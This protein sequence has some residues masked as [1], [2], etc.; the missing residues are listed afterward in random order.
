VSDIKAC[1]PSRFPEGVILEADFS[2]LEVVG[3]AMLTEDPV[4]IDDLLSGRDMHSYYTAER[5]N[6]PLDLVLKKLEVGD[7]AMKQQRFITKRMTFQLQYGSG[8][9]NMAKKLGIKVDDATAFIEAYYGRYERVKE[10]QE[11]VIASVKASRAPSGRFSKGGLPLG[12][13]EHYSPTGRSYAFLEDEKPPDWKGRNKEPDFNP[14]SMKNYPVQ[15]FA[16]GDIMAV[17]RGRVLREWLVSPLRA[18]VLPVNTVHDSIM[19]DCSSREDA[20]E[21]KK[22]LTRVA[23]ELQELVEL[24][25]GIAAPI[26]FKIETKIG[27]TWASTEK[28]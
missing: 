22:L 26:P 10:W 14:P 7:K 21:L 5:L 6:L 2:Q 23:N 8:A 19:F 16:T 12:R 25:W 18:K 24:T 1:F 17:F 11:E 20:L 4:L 9:P 15:G 13:G 28:V 27:P 3:L